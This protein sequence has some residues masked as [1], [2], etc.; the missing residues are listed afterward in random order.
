[1]SK[2][3]FLFEKNLMKKNWFCLPSEN[4]VQMLPEPDPYP[5]SQITNADPEHWSGPLIFWHKMHFEVAFCQTMPRVL[6][7]TSSFSSTGI[8]FPHPT[9]RQR[10]T[11]RRSL[12]QLNKPALL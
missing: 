12:R 11:S 6:T 8:Q 4:F 1:L 5:D 7:E 3:I 10:T 9:K 2:I